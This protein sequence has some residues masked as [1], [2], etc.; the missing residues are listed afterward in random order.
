MDHDNLLSSQDLRNNLKYIPMILTS[1]YERLSE[2]KPNQLIYIVGH[3][4]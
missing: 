4:L 3:E 1:D 2:K